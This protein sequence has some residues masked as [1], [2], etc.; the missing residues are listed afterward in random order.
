MRRLRN[1]QKNNKLVFK[2]SSHRL[3]KI[4]KI[5]K[6][7]YENDRSL[8]RFVFE[9]IGCITLKFKPSIKY[10][11]SVLCY[12]AATTIFAKLTHLLLKRIFIYLYE[13]DQN[14]VFDS[15]FGKLVVLLRNKSVLLV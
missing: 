13:P 11:K 7:N 14:F 1:D 5:M 15:F 9:I 4:I 2:S 3:I 10:K 6:I 12:P 8:D